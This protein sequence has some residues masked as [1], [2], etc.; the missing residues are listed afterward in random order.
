MKNRE[1]KEQ[2]EVG[3]MYCSID[4]CGRVDKTHTA[5]CIEHGRSPHR[6]LEVSDKL[7]KRRKIWKNK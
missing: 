5:C 2:I 4:G 6:I 7:N 3:D 1:T